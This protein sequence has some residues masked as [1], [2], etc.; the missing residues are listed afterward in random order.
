MKIKIDDG[1]KK[2]S[3]WIPERIFLNQLT[4]SLFP[5]LVKKELEKHGVKLKASSLRKFV[6]GYYKCKRKF[7]GKIELVDVESKNGEKVKIIL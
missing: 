5:G 7:G 3:L 6:R 4:V 2:F 1:R